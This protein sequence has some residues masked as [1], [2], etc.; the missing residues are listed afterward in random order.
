[1][2]DRDRMPGSPGQE[3]TAAIGPPREFGGYDAS[4]AALFAAAWLPAWTGNQPHRLAAFYT[5]D[6]FYSDSA[7][8]RSG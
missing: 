5:P 2:Q 3:L 6:T 1:M 8:P 4:Q 7:E